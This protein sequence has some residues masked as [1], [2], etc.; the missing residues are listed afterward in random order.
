VKYKYNNEG[1]AEFLKKLK[2][3]HKKGC[4]EWTSLVAFVENEIPRFR[5][6]GDKSAK[7]FSRATLDKRLRNPA[8]EGLTKTFSR[9]AFELMQEFKQIHDPDTETENQVELPGVYSAISGFW[10]IPTHTLKESRQQLPGYYLTYRPSIGKPGYV[11]VGILRIRENLE[12]GA[13]ETYERMPYRH[14]GKLIK[15]TFK[16]MIWQQPNEHF[17][18]LTTDSNTKSPQNLIL[19]CTQRDHQKVMILQ[20]SYSG[21][22]NKRE[23]TKIFWSKIYIVRLDSKPGTSGWRNILRASI[24]YKDKSEINPEICVRIDPGNHESLIMF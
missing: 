23:G 24:G 14:S 15:Q 17:F 18:M 9:A 21:I 20:G 7:G 8:K 4:L 3:S 19:R 6:Q 16:G 22:S 12:D 10:E 11:V 13:L 2:E 5:V 1:I